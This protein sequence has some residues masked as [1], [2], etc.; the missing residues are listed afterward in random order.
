MMNPGS[1]SHDKLM[2]ATKLIGTRVAPA[3][4]ELENDGKDGSVEG[5]S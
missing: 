1:L 5:M 3:L 4:R 2:R